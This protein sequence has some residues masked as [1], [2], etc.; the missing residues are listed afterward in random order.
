MSEFKVASRYAKALLDLSVEQ[1]AIDEVKTDMEYFI[2]VLKQNSELQAV[3]KNPIVQQDKK[4]T[5]LSLL[6]QEKFHPS[7]L[8]FFKIMVNKG[9][10]EILYGTSKE[11]IRAYNEYKGIVHAKVVSATALS[12]E[13]KTVLTA[14]IK[15]ST[16]HEV[17]LENQ[18][19]PTLI[20][21]FVVTVGDKQV[22]ASL[23]GRLNKLERAFHS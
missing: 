21:G 18:V 12:D 10:A 13:N 23:S 16:G 7:V 19:D 6:F 22:D 4:N 11:F 1:H 17:I 3:L 2:S 9:R 15:T 5:I 20:G 8:A 14:L